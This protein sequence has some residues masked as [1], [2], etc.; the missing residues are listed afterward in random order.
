MDNLNFDLFVRIIPFLILKK[1]DKNM[2]TKK[3]D[4]VEQSIQHFET[5]FESLCVSFS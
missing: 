5:F 4:K 2:T 1:M 3:I